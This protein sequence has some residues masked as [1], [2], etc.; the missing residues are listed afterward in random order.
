MI[1]FDYNI[2]TMPQQKL[3]LSKKTEEWRKQCV[4]A[5][6]ARGNQREYNGRT[7]RERK[8]INYDLVN[9]IF[10]ERDMEYIVNPYGISA[11][12]WNSPVKL[13]NF[14]I[15]RNKIELL[16]G[17]E[18]KR[19]FKFMAVGTSGKVLNSRMEAKKQLISSYLEQSILAGLGE[20]EDPQ[21]PLSEVLKEFNT[22]YQDIRE[23]FAN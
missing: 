9:S 19:P 15:I 10:D 14:N 18:I 12:K 20:G 8:R 7:S 16:K 4:D 17:E 5:L 23:R 6:I 22:T 21:K 2:S 3:P 13:E 11:N 1:D